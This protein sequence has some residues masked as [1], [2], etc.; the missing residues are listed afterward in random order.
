MKRTA[1][2]LLSLVS[3]SIMVSQTA[4]V[5]LLFGTN[6]FDGWIYT[7]SS[8]ELN[9][10]NINQDNINLYGNYTLIS[11]EITAPNVKSITVNVT[12]R[13]KGHEDSNYSNTLGK[14]Y[15]QL[16]N[17]KDSVLRE[18]KHSF[19]TKEFDRVFEV[20]FDDII[21]IA[22]TSFRLRLACWDANVESR[23]SVRKVQVTVKEYNLSGVLGD[24][25]NDGTVTSADITA[26]YDFLLNDDTSHIVNGDIN[27]DGEITS[28]DVTAVYSI[29]L[30]ES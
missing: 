20:D 22:D 27:D 1:L 23:F 12:G 13:T 25:N 2:L 9:N 17:D 8:T 21:D 29:L 10:S 26:L 15:V 19:K 5:L 16:I 11:P 28:A 24:V 6:H 30:G 7:Q 4:D 3:M 14:I 18:V